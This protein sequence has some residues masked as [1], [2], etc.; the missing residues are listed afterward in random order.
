MTK[1]KPPYQSSVILS[2][3]PE[4]DDPNMSRHKKSS[5][6][7][8]IH[9]IEVSIVMGV[10]P[11]IIHIYRWIFHGINHPMLTWGTIF[12]KAIGGRLIQALDDFCHP[13]RPKRVV[14]LGAMAQVGF[15]DLRISFWLNLWFPLKVRLIGYEMGLILIF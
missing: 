15:S 12:F 9:H 6:F 4:L 1:G 13:G 5:F 10:P 3:S 2:Q 11:V 8:D 7:V 14:V